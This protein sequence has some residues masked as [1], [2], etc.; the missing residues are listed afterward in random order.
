VPA[1]PDVPAYLRI[2]AQL[3]DGIDAGEW[4]THAALPAERELAERFGVSR[5]TARQAVGVLEREGRVYRRRPTG[6]FVA[7]PRIA[8]RLGSFSDEMVRHGRRAGARLVRSGVEQPSALVAEALGDDPV[9][10]IQRLRVADEEPVAVE[11]TYLPLALGE[12]V[13]YAGA[14][15][16]LWALLRERCQVEP[17]RAEATLEVS[18]LDAFT[19]DQLGV[20]VGTAALLLTR[21]TYDANE[22]CF[23]FA[24]DIYR[25][26]R[27]K[28]SFG[29]SIQ[30]L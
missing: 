23:E 26:D 19:A 8:L 2:A 17:T 9:F 29:D 5:M 7:E 15:G 13:A 3:R 11:S 14:K 10:A 4:G 21:W 18:V 6:T 24:R 27:A 16:S 20:G 28:F 1:L 22:E 12:E 30:Q 25:A